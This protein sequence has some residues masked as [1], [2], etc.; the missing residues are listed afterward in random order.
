MYNFFIAVFVG[1]ICFFV[2]KIFFLSKYDIKSTLVGYIPTFCT[3]VGVFF[4]FLTLYLVLSKFNPGND[5]SAI[6]RQLSGKFLFSIIGIGM[7]VG[8]SIYIKRE[9]S[10]EETIAMQ[11]NYMTKDP[12]EL[13]WELVELQKQNNI[14]TKD[15]WN[16]NQQQLF[17][18]QNLLVAMNNAGDYMRKELG[19]MIQDLRISLAAYIEI[20][21]EQSLNLTKEQA[22]LMNDEFVK[23]VTTLQTNMTHELNKSKELAETI[24]KTFE[25][26][27]TQ[28]TKVALEQ[29]NSIAEEFKSNSKQQITSL[30][31][32]YKNLEKIIGTLNAN[33]QQEIA[34]ILKVNTENLSKTFKTLEEMQTR[35]Q[36]ALETSSNKFREAVDAYQM[37]QNSNE[38]V[39]RQLEDQLENLR[40]L[41]KNTRRIYKK[42]KLQ[43][44]EMEQMADRTNAIA[45]MTDEIDRLLK[46][47]LQSK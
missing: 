45:N 6:V 28:S 1:I 33:I 40:R 47:L 35:S 30:T 25:G 13:L 41:V 10:Q 39:A 44:V 32:S 8:W 29:Q 19:T 38:E 34:E 22:K 24:I 2:P 27:I 46:T 18:H 7:G 14:K 12:Q 26:S 4:S 23:L 17:Q 15:I 42:W 16:V 20:M 5:L 3:S 31:E 37:T 21:G 36:T 11:K 9:L 43:E